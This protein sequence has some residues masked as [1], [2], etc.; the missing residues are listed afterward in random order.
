MKYVHTNL[1]AADWKKVANFY[2]EVFN[3]TLKT[4]ERNLKG[5]T[6][7]KAVGVDK[8]IITGVHLTLPGYGVNGPTL[9]IFQYSQNKKNTIPNSSN[10][11]GFRHIAFEVDDIYELI[12]KAISFGGELVGEV[13]E[14][15]I[16]EKKLIYVYLK[17]PEG[18]IIELQKWK[19]NG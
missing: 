12:K 5:E 2:I 9:E 18:N 15:Q 10:L 11:E 14:L 8:A 19:R 16:N 1:I 17:D 13:A 6:L 7:S 4:S 3:C